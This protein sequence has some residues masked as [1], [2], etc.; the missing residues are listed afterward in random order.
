[1][2]ELK[3]ISVPVLLEAVYVTR[4]L[5]RSELLPELMTT[6]RSTYQRVAEAGRM[7]RDIPG[8]P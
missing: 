1:M 3:I 7:K 5:A 4:E 2:C 8:R 6:I